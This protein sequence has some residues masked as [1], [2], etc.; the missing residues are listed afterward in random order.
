MKKS[1]PYILILIFIFI[2][3]VFHRYHYDEVRKTPKL[4]Y[5]TPPGCVWLH[6]NIFMDETEVR[7]LDYLEFLY[8]TGR[9]EPE[10]YNNLL[11][12]T[13]CWGNSERGKLLC[14]YYLRHPTFRNYPVVGVSYEQAVAFCKWRSDR[15][16][17]F[18]YIRNHYAH[19]KN[20]KW[21]T[22]THFTKVVRYSL[23]TKEEWEYASAAGLKY[24]SFLL[25]YERIVDK[26]N[27]PVS[28]TLESVN[29]FPHQTL[30]FAYHITSD[31]AVITTV[32]DPTRPVYSGEKNKFGI[33][34]LLGNVSE[35]IDD[36]LFKGL[37]YETAL[38]GNTFKSKK[39]DYQKIDS[40]L[41]GYDYKYTFR[42][43][44]PQAW[45]GFRCVC[46]VLKDIGSEY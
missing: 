11:P 14:Y 44:K 22:I 27:I 17:Q 26:K 31:S 43:Q 21:D 42:Y 29:L 30:L 13:L 18:L 40:T 3:C 33:S 7:N 41:N 10:K 12:D 37:N 1:I 6:D 19:I 8:W 5:E 32:I 9:E 38:D 16:N 2:G 35:I 25:G 4:K 46:D 36:T 28:Y 24:E 23:P 39:D 15:V 45:L 34:N 20:L